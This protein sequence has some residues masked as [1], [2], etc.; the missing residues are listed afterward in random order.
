MLVCRRSIHRLF[1]GTALAVAACNKPKDD[2][3]VAPDGSGGPAATASGAPIELAPVDHPSQLMPPG[4]ALLVTGTS[5]TRVAEVLGRDRLVAA[6]GEEYT[7]LR[8]ASVETLGHD[9]LDPM[10]WPELGLDPGGTVGVAVSGHDDPP[11]VL[12]ATISDRRTLLDSLRS[13]A[14]KVE[15][16]LVE[17]AYGTASIL[18][19]K[20]ISDDM[21]VV[22]RDR[23]MALVFAGD[24]GNLELAR[25]MVT[26]APDAS[27]ASRAEYRSATEGLQAADM[28]AYID[29]GGVF[30]RAYAKEPKYFMQDWVEE[31]ANT[32]EQARRRG[33][34]SDEIAKLEQELAKAKARAEPW[35]QQAEL[36]RAS[37]QFFASGIEGVAVT[38]TV[39]RSGPVF[40]GRVVDGP[41]SAMRR[42]AVNRS[43]ASALPMAM[44]GALLSCYLSRLDPATTLGVLEEARA[45][46]GQDPTWIRTEIMDALGLDVEAD[47][48]PILGGDMDL[49]LAVEGDPSA[50]LDPGKRLHAGVTVQV[51]DPAAAK[52]VLAKIAASG[53]RIG[54]RVKKRG[55]GYT[56]EYPPWG[57]VHVQVAGDLVVAS[58]DPELAKRLAAGDPGSMSSKI[59]APAAMD[60]I[61]LPGA[62]IT[63]VSDLSLY[64]LRKAVTGPVADMPVIVPGFTSEELEEIPLSA[65]SK[66]IKKGMEMAYAELEAIN[67]RRD[68][69]Q[70]KAIVRVFDGLGM[71][72]LAMTEDERGFTMTGGQFLRAESLGHV[73]EVMIQSLDE[74]STRELEPAEEARFVKL[75]DL[76]KGLRGAYAEARL[77][78]GRKYLEKRGKAAPVSDIAPVPEK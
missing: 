11:I 22:L 16:E 4:T 53:S 68:D 44:N 2:V 41:D 55:E 13:A 76:W 48:V 65:K 20:D 77:E 63:G 10:A 21:V 52:R 74:G 40:G 37:T 69:Q 66:K 6:L 43:G 64:I 17:E 19:P 47:L 62:A 42:L 45:A 67:A 49:C 34:S 39:E 46:V 71:F 27:L 7:L 29:V 35:R 75:R 30:R 70:A 54:K 50:G 14:G 23:F 8:S 59:R 33:A 56:V 28:V 61:G 5:M 51:T 38:V 3:V 26:M 25:Q 60:A 36:Q 72:V 58:T 32:L 18:W 15:M 78:D 24:E 12:V 73:L 57:I 1:L 31:Q 9:L